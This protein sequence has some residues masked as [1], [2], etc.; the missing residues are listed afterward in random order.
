MNA[1]LE[2]NR[3]PQFWTQVGSDTHVTLAEVMTLLQYQNQNAQDMKYSLLPPCLEEIKHKPFLESYRC[4]QFIL[5]EVWKGNPREHI[6]HYI[7][8]LG[9]Y[10]IDPKLRLREY[11][12]SL[13]GHAYT[14]S[15]NLKV[16]SIRS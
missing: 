5:F 12:K 4:S 14:W 16:G 6:S 10:A 15:I 3:T 9:Q 1:S 11:S 2:F 8:T 7:D 13:S